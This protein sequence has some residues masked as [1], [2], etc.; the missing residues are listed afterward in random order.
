[1][2]N[3]VY[4][5][6]Y[7]I[8]ILAWR[9]GVI[10]CSTDETNISL[11]ICP[12]S[13]NMKGSE[14]EHKSVAWAN[15]HVLL[16]YTVPKE[17]AWRACGSPGSVCRESISRYLFYIFP[18][19]AWCQVLDWEFPC[20]CHLINIWNQERGCG[21]HLFLHLF[22]FL[23]THPGNQLPTGSTHF[24]F[25]FLLDSAVSSTWKD[26]QVIPG[27]WNHQDGNLSHSRLCFPSQKQ[28][29]FMNKTALRE[30]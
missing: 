4:V 19:R 24:F 21:L 26:L 11:D 27:E 22:L 14:S 9:M 13:Q 10:F 17:E 2:S 1:M 3:T 18:L 29:V 16:Y 20:L 30:P 15:T 25:F 5:T 28:Q 8:L 23:V 12:G 7:L 6:S